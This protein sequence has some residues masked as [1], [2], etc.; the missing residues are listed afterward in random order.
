MK[1]KGTISVVMLALALGLTAGAQNA[2]D[3][4]PAQKSH[5]HVLSHV[6]KYTY[7]AGKDVAK[8]TGKAV[9]FTAEEIF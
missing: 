7:K 2:Q 8:A 9:A 1:I 3:D 6:A 4:Q 5:A